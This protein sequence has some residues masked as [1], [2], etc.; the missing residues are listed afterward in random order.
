MK[1]N[2]D[3][4]LGRALR[5]ARIRKKLRQ[6]YIAELMNVSKMTISHWETGNRSMTAENLSRYCKILGVTVQQIFDEM[7][8]G[9]E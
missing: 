5:K 4:R 3:V 7:E 2:F 6:P 9:D 1:N 8:D